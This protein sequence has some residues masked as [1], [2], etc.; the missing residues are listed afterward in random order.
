MKFSSM[1]IKILINTIKDKQLKNSEYIN[2][3]YVFGFTEKL[4][5][6]YK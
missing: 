2:I 5:F 4:K 1:F 6:Y 3:Y